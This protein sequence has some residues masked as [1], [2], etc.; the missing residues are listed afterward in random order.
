[1]K[2]LAEKFGIRKGQYLFLMHTGSGMLG[3]YASYFY[4]PKKK[5][6]AA[7]KLFLRWDSDDF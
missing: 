6:I 1:M 4:T 5:S 7:K 3:Q 2:D